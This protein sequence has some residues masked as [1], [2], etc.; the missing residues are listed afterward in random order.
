MKIILQ[1]IKFTENVLNVSSSTLRLEKESDSSEVNGTVT[2]DTDER[3]ATF[4]PVSNL[5]S[6][7][8]YVVL[9]TCNGVIQDASGNPLQSDDCDWQFKTEDATPPT[10][11]TRIP[12][13]N[14]SGIDMNLAGITVIFSEQ[15]KYVDEDNFILYPTG[16]DPDANKVSGTFASYDG[17]TKYVL[18]PTT[19]TLLP[20]TEYTVL[21]NRDTVSTYISDTNGNDLGTNISWNFTTG[22]ETDTIPPFITLKNPS[23][24]AVD[25][26]V[27]SNIVVFFFEDVLGVNNSTFTVNPQSGGDVNAVVTYDN[28]TYSATLNPV[29][30]LEQD[31]VYTVTLSSSIVDG[32]LNPLVGSPVSWNFTTIETTP[33]EISTRT[34]EPFENFVVLNANVIVTF[35][36]PVTGV[37]D[38]TFIL[39]DDTNST[40]SS[41]VRQDS[42]TQATLIPDFPL[43]PNSAY[44]V[45]LTNGI[46][47]TSSNTNSFV[48]LT[49]TFDTASATDTT[50]PTVGSYSPDENTSANL[51]S[52]IVI[53]FSEDVTGVNVSNVE[54]TDD[55][56]SVVP[57][58]I[59]YDSEYKTVILSPNADFLGDSTYTVTIKGDSGIRDTADNNFS[60]DFVWSFTTVADTAPPTVSFRDP[61]NGATGVAIG[62]SI[63]VRFN[64]TVQDVNET[65]FKLKKTSDGTPI[66]AIVTA[67]PGGKEFELAPLQPLEDGTG[68][69]Y[70]VTLTADITDTSSN[71]NP[72]DSDI[73]W[74]FETTPDYYAPKVLPGSEG[75]QPGA[76]GVPLN[77]NVVLTF[78]ESVR[79]NS[80]SGSIYVERTSDNASVT[81]TVNYD[82]QVSDVAT[83]TDLSLSANTEY[84]VTV[85]TGVQDF[86]DNNM[87]SDYTW[88]FT[89]GDDID[90]TAPDVNSSS[91]DANDTGV[92]T[93][94]TSVDVYFTEDVTG[95]TGS[96]F[97]L[98]QGTTVID[99]NVTTGP[100]NF[101]QLSPK[102]NLEEDTTYTVVLTGAITDIS[103]NQNTL[104]YTS[105]QFTT[106]TTD[107][108]APV[109]IETDPVGNATDVLVKPNITVT[110]SESI[111]NVNDT[112]CYLS[113]GVT[114]D[115]LYEDATKTITLI[116]RTSLSDNTTYTVTLLG[117]LV[118]PVIEDVAGNNLA[119]NYTFDFT[120]STAPKV[121]SSV[122]SDGNSGILITQSSVVIDFDKAMDTTTGL[123]VLSGGAGI[124]G[125]GEWSNGNE[126]ITYPIIGTLNAG[127]DYTVTLSSWWQPFKDVQGNPLNVTEN[128]TAVTDEV[129][130]F[131]T[132]ADGT[133]PEVVSVI[134]NE[135]VTVSDDLTHIVVRFNEQMNTAISTQTLS[136]GTIDS[137]TWLENGKTAYFEVSGLSGPCTLDLSDYEDVS[138]NSLNG[139]DFN[140]T[141][142]TSP[143]E[144][145]L[146]EGFN[147]DFSTFT[148]DSGDDEDWLRVD[149]SNNPSALPAEGTHFLKASTL[150]WQAGDEASVDISTPLDFQFYSKDTWVL[151]IQLAHDNYYSAN[152]R[153]M[154]LVDNTNDSTENYVNVTEIWRFD[155][156]LSVHIDTIV[157]SFDPIDYGFCA[158]AAYPG[159]ILTNEDLSLVKS[160]DFFIDGDGGDEYSIAGIIDNYNTPKKFF[161][162]QL[163][164][165]ICSR[166]CAFGDGYCNPDAGAE[167]IRYIWWRTHHIDL[168]SYKNASYVKIRLKAI[169]GGDVG[170]NILIDDLRVRGY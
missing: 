87:S 100:A 71:L 92:A 149:K 150:E 148:N 118:D 69:E 78:S 141:V 43:D 116:P 32:A 16:S 46:K 164:A 58:L 11:I 89:T 26:T 165:T 131:R 166:N 34:P 121:I 60:S 158:D 103:A 48:E 6:G 123:A 20:N 134:P 29:S 38:T 13:S 136:C 133:N 44:S 157:S 9:I 51:N 14:A 57:A 63:T 152:D 23:V 22:N 95:V 86:G 170:G 137:T 76:I 73:I 36:E 132:T 39:K 27:D 112:T 67:K 135:G 119:S 8:N 126:T 2:Y 124:L 53:I 82:Y 54:L 91:P 140:F 68:T 101:A 17:N 15:V 65:T 25:V 3:T 162:G 66:L 120:T 147:S 77:T 47:D 37:N 117:G 33:P 105:W 159:H 12:D 122:P 104:P 24:G 93:N 142:D 115:I 113:G 80:V 62:A 61:T 4:N 18:D 55:N 106:S 28:A 111:R 108:V 160:G 99:A 42:S 167:I 72:L 52:D 88:T 154:V 90:L 50:N 84:R 5:E 79:N 19:P 70:T 59:N 155:P 10:V 98:K 21:L 151:S 139:G 31:Q 168:S 40:V 74:S 138:S 81:A 130:D 169:S 114:V 41:F 153:L 129:I 96:S 56:G 85:T 128:L 1:L 102:Y 144:I 125:F 127:I 161:V 109:V 97:M 163:L 45:T 110:F 83:L 156:T 146:N 30:D 94:L 107:L 64:E 145:R 49:W 75:P 35:N 143:E 7:A